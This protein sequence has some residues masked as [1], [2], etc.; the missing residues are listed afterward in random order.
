MKDDKWCCSKYVCGT[1]AG[2]AIIP[3]SVGLGV[4]WYVWGAQGFW[5]GWLYGLFWHV[6]VGYRLAEYLWR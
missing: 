2:I 4:F 3:A 6:W 5:W 1:H